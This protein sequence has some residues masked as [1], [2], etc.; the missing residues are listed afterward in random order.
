MSTTTTMDDVRAAALAT[1]TLAFDQDPIMRWMFPTPERYVT[2]FPALAGVL[3][4][5]AFP[6]GSVD[7]ADGDV[8]VALWVPPGNE[9]DE[10]AL[11]SLLVNGIDAERHPTAFAFLEQVQGYH[12]TDEHWY[13]PFIGVD[14]RHQG[15]GIGSSV[16]K[17]GLARADR[18][19]LGCYLEASTPRNKVLYERHGFVA[20]GEIQA[21]D[22]PPLWPM[23]RDP[24]ASVTA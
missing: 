2:N 14:P 17:Q 1:L 16:L 11:V 21:G 3:G 19:G 22:S 6:A 7:R 12:P 20:T 5:P 10:D 13:L 15:Q 23:W 24:N 18:D 9:A 4:D 8:G